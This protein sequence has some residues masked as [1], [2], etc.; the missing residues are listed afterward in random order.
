MAL[1]ALT[2]DEKTELKDQFTILD[3]EE[4]GFINLNELRTRWTWRGSR[5]LGGE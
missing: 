1:K 3:K 5:C 2:D 4:S